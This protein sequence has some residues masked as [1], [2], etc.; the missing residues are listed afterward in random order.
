MIR[1]TRMQ[2]CTKTVARVIRKRNRFFLCSKTR[3]RKNGSE[4]LN[5]A[6]YKKEVQPVR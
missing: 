6:R 5:V 1:R 3:D 4:D 2:S